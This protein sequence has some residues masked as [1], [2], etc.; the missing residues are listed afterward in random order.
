M[1]ESTRKVILRLKEAR[2]QKNLTYQDI[3]DACEA[4]NES[5]SLSTVRRIFSK[6]SEDGADYR[7]YTIN[8]LFRAVIGT[9]DIALTDAEE[10]ALTETEK[11]AV[12]ENSALKAVVEM[13]D[14]TIA[15]L[16]QQIESLIAEKES[17][18]QK[19]SILQI[20]LETMTDIIRV[21]VEAIGKR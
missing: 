4:Q 9:E 14:A 8:A 3:V 11:E 7:P 5:I 19:V 17:L 2:A 6:G 15:D 20:K 21:S 10:A 1:Q 16:Q 18:E 12:T 13:K